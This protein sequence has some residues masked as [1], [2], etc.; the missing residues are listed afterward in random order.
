[1]KTPMIVL[2]AALAILLPAAPAAA[3]ISV[4]FVH[5]ERYS[6]GDFRLPAER[7]SIIASFASLFARL[8]ARDLKPDQTL[9]L[10]VL[11]IELAGEYEPWRRGGWGEVRILR[12]ITPPRFKMR[13]TLREKGKV[14][15]AATETVTDI[16][17]MMNP[18][19]R[20]AGR[21]PFETAMLEDWFRRRFV[22]LEPP[23]G[24]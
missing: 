10:E 20:N 9:A 6:D 8:G 21:F 11:D 22:R 1:M 23:R 24:M 19:A 15:F 14:V 12:D 5:P 13:Y 4:R 2:L 16:N 18:S 3:G 17:Y 7:E